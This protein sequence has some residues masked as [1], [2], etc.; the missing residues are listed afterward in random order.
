MDDQNWKLNDARIF[1]ETFDQAVRDELTDLAKPKSRI[2]IKQEVHSPPKRRRLSHGNR[3][4][5]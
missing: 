1:T 2:P 5:V 3:V 4:G